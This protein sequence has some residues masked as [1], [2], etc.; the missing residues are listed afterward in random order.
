ME[1]ILYPTN[2]W[3]DLK[4]ERKVSGSSAPKEG[5]LKSRCV[6]LN[7]APDESFEERRGYHS[8]PVCQNLEIEKSKERTSLSQPLQNEWSLKS[9][10]YWF[11]EYKREAAVVRK[12]KKNLQRK[13]T[14]IV[15]FRKEIKNLI[16]LLN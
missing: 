6:I 2:E 10:K 7:Q 11:L 5:V 15:S 1:N 16:N 4:D 3:G 14:K 13:E 9:K 12:L 8:Q